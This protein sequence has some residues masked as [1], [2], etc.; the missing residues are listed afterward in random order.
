MLM[1]DS[2]L[3]ITIGVPFG[4]TA[5]ALSQASHKQLIL[6]QVAVKLPPSRIAMAA[7]SIHTTSSSCIPRRGG[8]P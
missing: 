3:I 2:P 6:D 8:I 7:T 5:V 1:D 4:S